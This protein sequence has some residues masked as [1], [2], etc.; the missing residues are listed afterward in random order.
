MTWRG[1]STWT[2]WALLCALA[3]GVVAMHHVGMAEMS[4]SMAGQAVAVPNQ[5]VPNQAVPNQAV[6][7]QAVAGQHLSPMPS[8]GSHEPH[9]SGMDHGMLHLCLAVLCAV[10]AMALGLWFLRAVSSGTSVRTGL[11]RGAA[12]PRAPPPRPGR[13]ILRTFCVLRI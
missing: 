7:N 8:A 11:I 9:G 10:V 2:R 13:D 5:A 6:P 3:L 12:A 1:A 4:P